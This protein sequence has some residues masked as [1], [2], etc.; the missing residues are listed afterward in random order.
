MVSEWTKEHMY[1]EVKT[2]AVNRQGYIC[3]QHSGKPKLVFDTDITNYEIKPDKINTEIESFISVKKKNQKKK[4]HVHF[5]SCLLQTLFT[6]L[7]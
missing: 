6:M 5:F 1:I 4:A 3:S 2:N 7:S